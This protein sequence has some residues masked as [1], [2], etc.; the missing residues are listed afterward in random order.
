MSS[1]PRIDET[2]D[3]IPRWGLIAFTGFLG[4]YNTTYLLAEQGTNLALLNA[5]VISIGIMLAAFMG[6]GIQTFKIY[7]SGKKPTTLEDFTNS[8]IRVSETTTLVDPDDKSSD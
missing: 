3:I 1:H 4:E 2:L 8:R 6:F 5:N 7:L